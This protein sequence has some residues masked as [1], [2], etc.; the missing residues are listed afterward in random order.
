MS[1]L[2]RIRKCVT[3]STTEAGR[4]TMANKVKKVFYARRVPMFMMPSLG[5][6]SSG[7]YEDTK[8]RKSTWRRTFL[9]NSKYID[10]RHHILREM[11]SV[12]I[13]VQ[14]I[15]SDD[16]HADFLTKNFNALKSVS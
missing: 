12:N 8:R 4:A 3:L 13:S 11:A 1:W 10:V 7:V 9:S 14:H 2:S 5:A 16:Q 6:M 15:Q